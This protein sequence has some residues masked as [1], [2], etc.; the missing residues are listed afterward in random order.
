MKTIPRM[1]CIDDEIRTIPMIED[2]LLDARQCHDGDL[3]NFVAK[4][5][6]S[7]FPTQFFVL[8]CLSGTSEIDYVNTAI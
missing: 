6:V 8:S 2:P 1:D 3:G 4:V 7:H 5:D